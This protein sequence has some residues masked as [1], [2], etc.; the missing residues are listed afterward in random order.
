MAGV[1]TFAE[2]RNHVSHWLV[3]K[4]LR[5][6]ISTYYALLR[7]VQLCGPTT[8]APGAQGYEILLTGSFYS[9]N[10]LAAHLQP[11]ALS[12]HVARVRIVSTWPVPSLKNVE[13]ICPPRWLIHTVGRVTARM[14]TFVWVAFRTRPHIIGGFHLLL[15]GLLSVLLARLVGGRAMYFCVGGPAEMLGG[16][17]TS[18]NRLF[19][20]LRRPDPVL[21]RQLIHAV[22]TF[23]IVIT[24]GQRA[25]DFF[26]QHG[27]NTEF[28][29]VSGGMD[30]K[31]FYASETLA[32]VDLILVAR[33]VPIKRIDIFLE[34]VRHVCNVLPSVT[35]VIVGD[36]PLRDTLQA[37]ADELQVLPNIT[38]VG[39]Q[40]NVE[41][42]LRQAKIF[43]L[44]SQSEGLALSLMEAMFCGLPAVV[45]N[46]GDLSEL[47]EDGVNGYLVNEHT[48]QDFAHHILNLLTN[49]EQ[50]VQF[51]QA[52]RTAAQRYESSAIVRRW[53]EVI[54]HDHPVSQAMVSSYSRR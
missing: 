42:W 53:D 20:R 51:S 22:S 10:W 37:K 7:L 38:F 21:E 52:A 26:R 32:S 15:N 31:R 29:V 19:E 34:T 14:L 9:D 17:V 25:I 11:L 30:A 35:A 3:H 43:V 36:G 1:S 54:A 40:A 45:P 39:H 5:L 2:F 16:G 8:R 24:M 12:R 18:E 44:T 47:V 13:A 6:F 28:H 41:N 50:Y 48:P 46:V 33:L 4:G 23:D 49:H 27:I